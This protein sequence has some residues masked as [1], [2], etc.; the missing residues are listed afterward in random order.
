MRVIDLAQRLDLAAEARLGLRAQSQD[1]L[2]GDLPT[3]RGLPGPIDDA[4]A[5]LAELADQL[6]FADVAHRVGRC[7]IVA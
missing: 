5:P 2:E 1:H 4:H 6:K 3:Q 7:V